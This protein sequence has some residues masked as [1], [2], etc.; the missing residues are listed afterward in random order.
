M[1]PERELIMAIKTVKT[2][3]DTALREEAFNRLNINNIED[4]Q[5]VNA[6]QYGI[7]LTDLN[8]VERYVRIGVIVAEEREDV[9]ARELMQ[10]EIDKYEATQNKKAV[11]AKERAEKAEADRQRRLEKKKEMES[12]RE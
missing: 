3:T 2:V 10:S 6:R 5:R 4:F 11:K 9:T 12:K 7:L 1:K 8:G